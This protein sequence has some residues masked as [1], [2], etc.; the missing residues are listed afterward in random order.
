MNKIILTSKQLVLTKIL[1]PTKAKVFGDLSVGDIVELSI[2]VEAAGTN[3][4]ATYA[5]YIKVT[6]TKTK[7]FVYK[8]FNEIA[9]ILKNFIF[10]EVE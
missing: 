1:K 3:R 7:D 4:G 9:P 10:E 2:A 6:N 5:S 8:S